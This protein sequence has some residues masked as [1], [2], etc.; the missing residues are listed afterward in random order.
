MKTDRPLIRK[1]I[2]LDGRAMADRRETHQY[3]KR[4]FDFPD[5]Y[6]NNLDALHDLLT[7]IG[8]PVKVILHH[9]AALL[10]SQPD[11]GQAILRVLRDADTQNPSLE[12]L[13]DD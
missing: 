6:G 5:Y 11:Y 10:D 12:F 1:I 2:R 4:R 7:E 8:M 9:P 13:I 3:L